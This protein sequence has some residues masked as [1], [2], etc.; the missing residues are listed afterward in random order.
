MPEGEGHRPRNIILLS[1]GTG[2][3]SSSLFK[4]NVRR[5]YE[6]IDL[7]DPQ[8]PDH[9]R[10]FAFYD[11][12]VGT[13]SFRP[14]T[15]LGGAFGFGLARNIR[16]IYAFLCRTYRP[17]DHIYAFGFSRGAFTIRTVVAL[18]MQQGI[19][20]HDGNEAN[21][22]RKV[23]S[24]YREFR[25]ELHKGNQFLIHFRPL[26]DLTIKVWHRLT[27]VTRAM[28]YRR[29]DNEG[30]EPGPS[31]VRVKFVGV[32]DTVDA[33]GLPIEELTRA[34]DRFILPLN[35]A[36][37]DLNP[38]VDRARHALALDEQ[39]QTFHPR[40]WNEHGEKDENRIRQVWFAG[41][42][43]D[44]GGGYPDDGLAHVTLTWMLSQLEA[45]KAPD[46]LRLRPE[47]R[48]ALLARADENGPL[49]DSRR[50]F[51][52]Y[53]RYRPRDIE[54]LRSQEPHRAAPYSVKIGTPIL[55][56]SALRR[57]AVGQDGYAPI[58]SA[59]N[60]NVAMVG[61]GYK[62][63]AEFFGYKDDSCVKAFEQGRKWTFNYV[64]R[65]RISYFL[66]LFITLFIAAFPAFL[67]SQGCSGWA[68]FMSPMILGVGNFLPGALSSWTTVAA[69]NP[70]TLLVSL[71]LLALT[72]MSGSRLER[73]IADEMRKVWYSYTNLKP[74]PPNGV[75]YSR[76][77]PPG[78]LNKAIQALRTSGG[79]IGF[80][81]FARR[82]G[83][84]V[85]ASL[86]TIYLGYALVSVAVMSARESLGFVCKGNPLLFGERMPV[87]SDFDTSELCARTPAHLREGG[88]YIIEISIPATG[89]WRDGGPD[90]R[91][92]S[93]NGLMSRPGIRMS[94]L[95][96]FRRHWG[97]PW[98]KVM[99]RVG[100]NGADV[101]APDWRLVSSGSEHVYR[102]RITSHRTGPLFLYVNDGV[103]L[104]LTGWIYGN[105]RGTARVTVWRTS[106]LH[107]TR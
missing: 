25:R 89:S 93:P 78:C 41:V 104:G 64:W 63:S 106:S 61:G 18:I 102:A 85:L 84:P 70:A 67:K 24:A 101:Q 72:Y 99:A 103:A 65:R 58:S 40:L 55:H 50:G 12:G 107:H 3:S 39:R 21:L 60:F 97:Q 32:W 30:L 90:G 10:Q 46:G 81:N 79:Y 17:G 100:T 71:G 56:Q 16:E 75:H 66:A 51:A 6:A 52:S 94:L 69:A 53:Y 34:I 33:Y 87:R 5:L 76:P 9:P 62:P 43:S 96:P 44:V 80:W 15:L 20:K 2:N 92:A 95:A 31:P 59:L 27:G 37:A 83:L 88:R 86:G 1:D 4:T 29:A 14:L 105:N 13:S 26:R 54:I 49:H 73:R 57:I 38:R 74:K 98:F 7:A 82:W 77:E 11:D 42:H 47:A 22:Q 48:D 8:N 36:N 19:V 91:P 45:D 35:M 68:C 23:R 28:D